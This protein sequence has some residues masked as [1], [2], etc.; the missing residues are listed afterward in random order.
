[1]TDTVKPDGFAED[2]SRLAA[3]HALVGR[4]REITKLAVD[5]R[6]LPRDLAR[7]R[8]EIL[9]CLSS[10]L[11]TAWLAEQLDVKD[12]TVAGLVRRARQSLSAT[13]TAEGAQA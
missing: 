8:A 6:T 4:A 13:R 7:E 10:S 9:L 11:K 2:A 3:T 12:N 1:M 5:R